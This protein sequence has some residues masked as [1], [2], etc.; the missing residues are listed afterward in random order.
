MTKG[1]NEYNI[2]IELSV[3]VYSVQLSITALSPGNKDPSLR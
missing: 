1:H 3:R 2:D